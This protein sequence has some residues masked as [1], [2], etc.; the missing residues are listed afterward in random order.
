MLETTG[1]DGVMIARGAIGNPW[2]FAEALRLLHGLP[3]KA[4]SL[5]ERKSVLVEHARLLSEQEGE[6]RA[7]RKMRGLL[8]W[9]TKGLPY[10][11]RF[12]ERIA[13]IVDEETLLS[14][15]DEFFSLLEKREHE[16]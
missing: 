14:L 12:R 8:L 6:G 15:L 5:A 1:C 2:I 13:E 16:G 9:Y 4:P 3:A 10:S 7:A 11:T